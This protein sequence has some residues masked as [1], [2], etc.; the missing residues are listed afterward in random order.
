MPASKGIQQ[1]A[2]LTKAIATSGQIN[3]KTGEPLPLIDSRSGCSY[4]AWV[5]PLTQP[6][7]DKSNQTFSFINELNKQCSL[8]IIVPLD[9][10]SDHSIDLITQALN[11]TQAEAR[12]I[13]AL[14]DGTTL[15]EYALKSKISKNTAKN[16]L[17]N[18]YYK[19]G[20]TR[21]AEL[22]AFAYKL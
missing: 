3:G 2:A 13:N 9:G 5:L 19:T 22:V 8:V 14:M 12:L 1:N 15:T 20:T 7:S 10:T 21:Q 17:A 16:H 6:N 11:V 18:I 4:M